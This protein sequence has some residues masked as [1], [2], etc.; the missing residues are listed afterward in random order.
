MCLLFQLDMVVLLPL[1]W[2]SI[3]EHN[4]VMLAKEEACTGTRLLVL[5]AK[6]TIQSRWNVMT[7]PVLVFLV[8]VLMLL[9]LSA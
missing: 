7:S 5:A 4:Q 2:M 9:P 1:A 8:P 6:H 3:D